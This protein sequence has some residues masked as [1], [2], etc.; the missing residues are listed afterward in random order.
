[1]ASASTKAAA[2][3]PAKTPA[4]PPAPD[5]DRLLEEKVGTASASTPDLATF[6]PREMK[7]NLPALPPKPA[8]KWMIAGALA[9]ALLLVGAC[10]LLLAPG[11]LGYPPTRSLALADV[12][13]EREAI[14]SDEMERRFG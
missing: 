6:S 14:P 8:P 1:E 7:K 2:P 3:A 12:K 11:W 5:F 4:T 13:V 10:L 9:M